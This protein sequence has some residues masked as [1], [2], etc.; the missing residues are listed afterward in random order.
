MCGC[1]DG[2]LV[3][4]V[5]NDYTNNNKHG[6]ND[7]KNINM[8][9]MTQIVRVAGVHNG[10]ITQIVHNKEQDKIWTAGYDGQ[11]IGWDL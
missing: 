2:N 8:A 1:E 10:A 5:I 7:K 6:L 3:L 9:D 11:V 4:I